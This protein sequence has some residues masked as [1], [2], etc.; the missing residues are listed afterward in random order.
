MAFRRKD[1]NRRNVMLIAKASGTAIAE[2][3]LVKSGTNNVTAATSNAPIL[4]IALE[5][6]GSASTSPIKVDILSPGEWI[7]GD[8]ESGT[9]AS[10]D[11]NFCDINSADGVTLSNTNSDFR[12]A[13]NGTTTTVDLRPSTV[14][15]PRTD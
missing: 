13:Y 11:W 3:D 5:A 8:V 4:G 6:A 10:G 14:G 12:Y 2:G 1:P 15:D 7:I 9:P